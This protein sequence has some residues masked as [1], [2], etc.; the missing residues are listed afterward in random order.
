ADL[1]EQLSYEKVCIGAKFI[2]HAPSGEF[3]EVFND[4]LLLLN[5]DTLLREGATHAYQFTSVKTEGYE[6][7]VLRTEHGNLGNRKFLEPKN[8]YIKKH[9]L[10]GAS[11]VYAKAFWNGHWRSE[12]TFKSFLQLLSHK[13]I[14]DSLTVSNEIVEAKKNE[15]QTVISENYQTMSDT[16]FKALPRR[17][18]ITHT[19]IDWNKILNYKTG[20]EMQNALR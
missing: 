14:Q 6:D 19:K 12:W 2:I 4:I 13:D 10:N 7:Q 9:Y 8:A 15:Y 20:K 5:N 11:T 3:N 1:E 17:F 16:T 18:P